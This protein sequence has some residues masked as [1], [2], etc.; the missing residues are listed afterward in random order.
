MNHLPIK[1]RLSIASIKELS[2]HFILHLAFIYN[3]VEEFTG[4]NQPG[5]VKKLPY[6]IPMNLINDV[7]G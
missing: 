3:Q 2:K 4:L 5:V 6:S 1:H 7:L